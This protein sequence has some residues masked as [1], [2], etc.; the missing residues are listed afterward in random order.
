MCLTDILF[1]QHHNNLRFFRKQRLAVRNRPILLL[2]ATRNVN[3][4]T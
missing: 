4:I 2:I 1:M 3:F